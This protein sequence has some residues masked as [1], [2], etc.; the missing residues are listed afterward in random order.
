MNGVKLFRLHPV[1]FV[2]HQCSLK[3]PR[4]E[5]FSQTFR[6]GRTV[7]PTYSIASR[8]T[9]ASWLSPGS[10][11]PLAHRRPIPSAPTSCDDHIKRVEFELVQRPRSLAVILSAAVA[12]AIV[13]STLQRGT[14]YASYRIR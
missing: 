11:S 5:T 7:K 2:R 1:F 14:R 6:I 9:A 10:T 13:G 3:V 12:G 4:V 8:A